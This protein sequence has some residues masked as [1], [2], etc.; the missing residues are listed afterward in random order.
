MYD[1]Y[2]FAIQ[3]YVSEA[4][5]GVMNASLMSPHLTVPNGAGI[6]GAGIW[7][8]ISSW[9]SKALNFLVNGGLSDVAPA[10]QQGATLIKSLV[11]GSSDPPASGLVKRKI[12]PVTFSH[13]SGSLP[14]RP[15]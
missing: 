13:A 3:N 12:G 4:G 1:P 10:V 5:S 14:K 7:D 11:P 8:T 15:R 9:A 6:Y 2:H